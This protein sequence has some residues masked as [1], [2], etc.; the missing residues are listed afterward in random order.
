VITIVLPTIAMSATFFRLV[1][2]ARLNKLWWDDAF[3]FFAMVAIAFRDHLFHVCSH[4]GARTSRISILFTVIRL[5]FGCLRQVLV[6]MSAGFVLLWA[7]LF[8]QVWWVCETE[9]SWKS[10]LI[11]Q[12]FLGTNVAIAQVI[13][14]VACNV[15]LIAAPVKLLY[16]IVNRPLKIRL[17]S[18]FSTTIVT[19]A[20]SLYH[21]YV[22]L[23]IG[24]TSE[25]TAAL[26]QTSIG[27]LI[28][29]LTVLVAFL[30]RLKPQNDCD[31]TSPL[32]VTFG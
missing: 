7:I 12:C 22:V 9:P 21:A 11:P 10:Q 23:R 3:A 24:G 6:Y 28:A 31:N 13:T 30:F 4:Y 20:T 2:R 32:T 16:N 27:L 17:I 29:N 18:V 26:I 14:D 15:V 5:S 8:A 19:T 1:I 25:A